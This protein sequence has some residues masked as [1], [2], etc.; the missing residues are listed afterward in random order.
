VNP[1]YSNTSTNILKNRKHTISSNETTK[2]NNMEQ[3]SLDDTLSISMPLQMQVNWSGHDHLWPLM[4]DNFTAM[5][6]HIINICA[7]LDWNP[8]IKHRDI[9]SF[10]IC[11]NGRMDN[12]WT[13]M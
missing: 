3:V 10:R 11:V 2:Q 7:K 1:H 6:S 12:R 5:S 8:S 4:L 13:E 9:A